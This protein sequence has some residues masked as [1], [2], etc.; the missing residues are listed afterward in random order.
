MSWVRA[1]ILAAGLFFITMILT[2]QLPG[3]VYTVTTGARLVHLEDGMLDIALVSLGLAVL[4]MVVLFLFDPKPIVPPFLVAAFGLI[5]FAIGLGGLIYV[6]ASGH[7]FLPDSP[8]FPAGTGGTLF[9]SIWLQ[10]KSIDLEAI[11]M[12]V[13]GTGF[14][15]LLYGLIALASSS[16]QRFIAGWAIRV[17][18]GLLV[19]F[20]VL[21]DIVSAILG[22]SSSVAF[23]VNTVLLGLALLLLFAWLVLASFSQ[24]VNSPARAVLAWGA[25][26]VSAILTALYV[27]LYTFQGDDILGLS[28]EAALITG[29]LMMGIALLLAFAAV[30]I[31]F[32]PVMIADRRRYMSAAYLLVAFGLLPLFAIFLVLFLAAYPLV[33]WV[34]QWDI[35]NFWS[36]C[37]VKTDVPA[38]CTYT[39]YTGYIV[40]TVVNGQFFVAGLAAIRWW[41]KNRPAVILSMVV[42]FLLC[43]F[44]AIVIHTDTQMR[45][46]LFIGTAVLLLAMIWTYSTRHEFASVAQ[47]QLGCAGQ[48]LVLGT[49]ILVY[50]A[51]FAFFSFQQFF[52]TEALG[53]GY[54]GGPNQ[55]HDAFWSFLVLAGLAAIQFVVLARR[56][57]LSGMRKF[58]LWIVSLGITLLVVSGVQFSLEFGNG[59]KGRLLISGVTL[60]LAGLL[61]VVVGSAFEIFDALWLGRR[62]WGM[63][64]FA[65]LGIF[66]LLSINPLTTII[67]DATAPN[68]IP[69]TLAA[70]QELMSAWV[71]TL[72]FTM[73]AGSGALLSSVVGR[74]RRSRTAA[75]TNG[76][77]GVATAMGD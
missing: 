65:C 55:L 15:T 56:Y 23:I 21:F 50:L 61:F 72:V 70:D 53:I 31:W 46:A 63:L 52:E 6:Y 67:K 57:T 68:G 2:S 71:S 3:Y 12:I 30:Q 73:L 36:V 27:V 42:S 32:L 25:A 40:A 64:S 62:F 59:V 29:N 75:A 28:H 26:I 13:L 8:D 54:T 17:F 58:S 76:A 44:A 4:L 43:A 10:A 41:H 51:G 69:Y 11:S 33:Y 18:I 35:T 7:Q 20:S 60:Y 5:L 74:M 16:G 14:G 24:G 49:V 22:L 66:L 9:G 77:A 34:H 1:I 19:V 37:A 47:V 38:T 39:Q 48:W 45:V